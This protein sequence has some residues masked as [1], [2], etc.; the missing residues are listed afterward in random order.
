MSLRDRL[1]SKKEAKI[2]AE[3]GEFKISINKV[4]N[5]VSKIKNPADLGNIVKEFAKFLNTLDAS[6]AQITFSGNFDLGQK[7]LLNC[8][9]ANFLDDGSDVKKI[10]RCSDSVSAVDSEDEVKPA[11]KLIRKRKSVKERL[12]EK[13]A[14]ED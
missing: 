10:K 1:K 8:V 7:T 3:K 9:F 12:A 14:A 2:S 5:A 11:S 13:E 4:S 6:D